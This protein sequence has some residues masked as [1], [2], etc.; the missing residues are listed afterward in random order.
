MRDRFIESVSSAAVTLVCAPAGYGKSLLLADWIENTGNRDKAWVTLD[1]GDRDPAAFVTALL[2]AVR[3][4]EMVPDDAKIHRLRPP[5]R[6]DA[7]AVLVSLSDAIG[8]LPEPLYLVLDDVQSVVGEASLGVLTALVRDQPRNLR[9]VLAACA[10]PPL[11]LARLRVEGRLAE[12]RSDQLRFTAEEVPLLLEACGVRLNGDQVRRLMEMTDGWVAGLRLAARSLRDAPSPDR[13]LDT[14]AG[15]DGTIADFLAGEVLS[16]LPGRTRRLLRLLSVCEN[17]TPE[18]ASTLSGEADAGAV[19]AEL[20]RENSL[21]TALGEDKRW[22]RIHPLLRSYLSADLNRT[23]PELV[24]VLHKIVATSFA[25]EGYNREALGHAC[26]SG[27]AQSVVSVLRANA[28]EM[29]LT[30][31]A[32]LVLEGLAAAGRAAVA[33]DPWLGLFSAL[34]WLEK[35][36]FAAAERALA[37]AGTA[38]NARLGPAFTALR[39]LIVSAYSCA[40]GRLLLDDTT[41]NPGDSALVAVAATERAVA[42]AA[43]GDPS[44]ADRELRI[45]EHLGRKHGLDYLLLH[46][47]VARAYVAATSG[48]FAAMELACG[49]ALAHT[50]GSAW[51]DSPW[52]PLCGALSGLVKLMRLDPAGALEVAAGTVDAA[53]P[54]VRFA[55]ALVIG[56]ARFD[57]GDRTGG[58]EMLYQG[59]R[60]LGDRPVNVALAATAALTE[61]QCALEAGRFP[62]A[63]EVAAWATHRLGA[64]AEVELMAAR[65]E[66]AQGDSDTA[67]RL[68]PECRTGE[69][70]TTA[71]ESWLLESALALAADRRTRARFALDTA[72]QLASPVGILRPFAHAEPDVRRLLVDQLGGFGTTDA[73]ARRVRRALAAGESG[74]APLTSREHAV[75]VRLT[76]PQPLEEIAAQLSVSVNTVKTHVRAIY[77]KLGVTNR[78][79][80]VVVARER[81]LD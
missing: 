54:A 76:A 27:D 57:R 9:L 68:L 60:G 19:L 56:A 74:E 45:S 46:G 25:G 64:G 32:D 5:R 47:E 44:G 80:A 15:D 24:R 52:L 70:P 63:R 7:A 66:L 4:C 61:H 22:Y 37:R 21:L 72:L 65:T 53:A 13:F 67:A 2:C 20:E 34:A 6:T 50:A 78:R 69:A 55:G 40:T 17:V 31:E 51:Q 62:I 28:V 3:E 38:E 73:F 8:L 59:R 49:R 33:A 75:L 71:V 30:G 29:L 18:L 77:A 42:L 26:Q 43:H 39:R 23:S 10:D 1:S 41:P 48:D 79:E 35:G 58:L 16:Q 36:E 12:F 14:Y 81:G 11:P